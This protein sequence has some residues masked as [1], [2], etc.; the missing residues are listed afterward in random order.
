MRATRLSDMTPA[1]PR[2]PA[3]Y[4]ADGGKSCHRV[5]NWLWIPLRNRWSDVP[6]KPE[7]VVRQE[8][9]RRLVVEGGFELEQMDQ[10]VRSLAHGHGSPRADSVVWP[11]ARARANAEA[12]ILVV[13]TKAAE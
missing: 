13:E 12:S 1:P 6:H 9:V 10:E 8:W 11:S 5:G 3:E 4:F 2:P 7:E